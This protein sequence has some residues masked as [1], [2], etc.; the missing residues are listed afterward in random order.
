M[1]EPNQDWQA[2]SPPE[3]PQIDEENVPQMSEIGSLANIFFEPGRTFEFLRSKPKF[4]MASLII[5][6]VTMTFQ[7]LFMQKMGEERIKRAVVEQ[8]DKNPQIQAL[9]A[10]QKQKIIDQ[11]M[12]IS[13][14]IG[15]YL[16]P[17]LI[18]VIFAI[19]GALYWL[20]A[21]IMGGSATFLRGLSV[22]V[23]S[24]FPPTVM[25]MLANIIILFLK[26]A[27]D[28]DIASAQRGLVHAN[29]SL[30]FDGK[31]MPVLTTLVSTIDVF[32]IWGWVLAAIGLRVVAKISS[33][34]AW[35]VVAILALIGIALRVLGAVMSGNPS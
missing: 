21:N 14:V 17:V 16:I 8:L 32:Q 29:P 30:L 28:I 31:S 5:I 22:C 20:G 27:D 4:L 26:E 18:L 15:R 13:T 12:S 3:E 9:P 7:I 24:A 23:Y 19:I 1:T 2:S 34:S 11:Q 6:V 33:V 35:S 10:D 25:G